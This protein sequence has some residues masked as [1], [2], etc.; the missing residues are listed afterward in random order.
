MCSCTQVK[1]L[2]KRLAELQ[3]QRK[4]HDDAAA[5]ADARMTKLSA[6]IVQLEG[7]AKRLAAALEQVCGLGSKGWQ[8]ELNSHAVGGAAGDPTRHA[9]AGLNGSVAAGRAPASAHARTTSHPPALPPPGPGPALQARRTVREAQSG[10]AE[11]KVALARAEQE[12]TD[13]E[14][15]HA[16]RMR[17]VRCPSNRDQLSCCRKR[18]D[19]AG[20]CQPAVW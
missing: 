10:D 15:R 14:V 3:A 12:L 5:A 6:D 19:R 4:A 13:V 20:P 11:Q 9:P 2:E 16:G 1:A 17:A 18:V 8:G 7:E